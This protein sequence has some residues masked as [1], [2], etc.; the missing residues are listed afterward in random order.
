MI[1]KD[2][3]EKKSFKSEGELQLPKM[4]IYP[5]SDSK[6]TSAKNNAMT[7]QLTHLAKLVVILLTSVF[8]VPP[9]QRLVVRRHDGTDLKA[10]GGRIV[11]RV[12]ADDHHRAF[13]FEWNHYVPNFT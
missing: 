4:R 1:R 13:L 12:D 5:P 3:G 7:R 10:L 2:L 6:T 11:I 8:R 9:R